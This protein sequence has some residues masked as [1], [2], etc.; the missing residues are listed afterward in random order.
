MVGFRLWIVE[1][2]YQ[3]TLQIDE[4]L[5]MYDSCRP[6]IEANI[7]EPDSTPVPKTS[8]RVLKE[9]SNTIAFHGEVHD[10]FPQCAP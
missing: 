6:S 4:K 8:P 5:N 9:K 2:I 7:G 10:T 3:T 1:E